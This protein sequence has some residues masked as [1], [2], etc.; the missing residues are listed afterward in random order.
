VY[1]LGRRGPEGSGCGDKVKA[2]GCELG[3]LYDAR[4]SEGR[5]M[6]HQEGRFFRDWNWYV[7]DAEEGDRSGA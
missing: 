2:E 4:V 3:R 5:T 6:G 7:F 1:N